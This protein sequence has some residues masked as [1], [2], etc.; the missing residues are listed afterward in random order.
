MKNNCI[1]GQK[2]CIAHCT[3]CNWA[4][5]KMMVSSKS[6]TASRKLKNVFKEVHRSHDVFILRIQNKRQYDE[7]CWDC[8]SSSASWCSGDRPYV[9]ATVDELVYGYHAVFVLIHL[10][11]EADKR[12]DMKV[13]WS[14]VHKT[15]KSA[16]CLLAWKNTSTC[17]RGVSSLRTGY[18]HF[19]IMS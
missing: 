12:R 4:K 10:L 16:N 13:F 9:L 8:A 17:W 11:L 19:P 3:Q 2:V 6:S 1:Y 7:R 5:L 14:L 18:V 15:V